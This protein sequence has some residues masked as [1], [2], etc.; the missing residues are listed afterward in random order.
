MKTAEKIS[1]PIITTYHRYESGE[2]RKIWKKVPEFPEK[3]RRDLSK[4]PTALIR[5][6]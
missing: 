1:L 6:C 5:L 2:K 4:R 3:P